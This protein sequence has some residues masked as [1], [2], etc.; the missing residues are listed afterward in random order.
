MKGRKLSI[1]IIPIYKRD[2]ILRAL[3]YFC[4]M[5]FCYVCLQHP[6][7][8]VHYLESHGLFFQIC[9]NSSHKNEF[10]KFYKSFL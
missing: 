2:N 10:K 5:P 6:N 9:T 7:K 4:N 1:D 3:A 8:Y